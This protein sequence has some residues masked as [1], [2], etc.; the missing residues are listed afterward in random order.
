MEEDEDD[1][2]EWQQWE[3]EQDQQCEG[4]RS[5][6]TLTGYKLDLVVLVLLLNWLLTTVVQW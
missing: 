6:A 2:Q 4:G 5:G 3:N 1:E